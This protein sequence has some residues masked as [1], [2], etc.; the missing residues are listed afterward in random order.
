[1]HKHNGYDHLSHSHIYH[2]SLSLFRCCQWSSRNES[3]ACVYLYLYVQWNGHFYCFDLCVVLVCYTKHCCSARDARLFTFMI[4]CVCVSLK[5]NDTMANVNLIINERRRRHRV[6]NDGATIFNG[7][8][9]SPLWVCKM[10]I[11]LFYRVLFL[12]N[13]KNCVQER[14][15]IIIIKWSIQS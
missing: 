10:C 15:I 12:D 11:L 6:R 9:I 3:R 13:D 7:D 5:R 14:V 2:V 1:M 8:E 4:V